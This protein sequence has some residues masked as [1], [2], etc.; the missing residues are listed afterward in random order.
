MQVISFDWQGN[1][2][3]GNKVPNGIYA[4]RVVVSGDINN[5]VAGKIIKN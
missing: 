2:D 3:S 5:V 4:Y 1:N